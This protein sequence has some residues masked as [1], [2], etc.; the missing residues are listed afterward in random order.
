MSVVCTTSVVILESLQLDTLHGHEFM[1]VKRKPDRRK[2]R[3]ECFDHVILRNPQKGHVYLLYRNG[4]VV[5]LGALTA[6]ETRLASCWISIVLRKRIICPVEIKNIVF[7][8][9][10]PHFKDQEAKLSLSK[11]FFRLQEK[12]PRVQYEPELSPALMFNAKTCSTAKVMIFRTGR[13][14]ITGI[15]D[16][17]QISQLRHEIETALQ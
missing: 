1:H 5:I 4:K 8:Y 12:Y 7:V 10:S 15:R 9:T 17:T 16:F 13:V 2:R 3:T 6:E 14:N 11:L